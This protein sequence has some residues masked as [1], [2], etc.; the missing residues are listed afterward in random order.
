[1]ISRTSTA[2]TIPLGEILSRIPR[3]SLFAGKEW[4]WAPEPYRLDPK[5]V[6]E[7]ESMGHRLLQFNRACELLYR[8]SVAGKQ[9]AWIASLLDRGKPDGVVSLGRENAFKGLTASV[10]RPDL[11]LTE[12]GFSLCELDQIPGGIGLTAWLNETYSSLGFDV[13]GGANGMLEG[14]AAVLPGGEIVIS[15]EAS[16]YRPE[17]EWIAGRLAELKGERRWHVLNASAK[18]SWSGSVYRFFEMFDLENVPC[19]E[20]LFRDAIGGRVSVT[21]PPKAQLEEKLWM[22]LFWMPPLR[23]FWIRQLG[24]RGVETLRKWIP[25]TWILD[26]S[27]L[28]P[29]AVYPRL[30]IQDWREMAGF[31]QKERDLVIKISGFD[32]RAWGARGVRLGSDLSAKEWT[33]AIDAALSEFPS[34]PHILQVF[35]HSVLTEQSFYGEDGSLRTMKGKAR[36]SPYFFVADHKATLG[37]VLATVCPADKKILHGM[38]VAVMTPVM[39]SR[40]ATFS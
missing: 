10:I 1:V 27:P 33:E 15:E 32:G 17:M 5:L 14:F 12:E 4:R 20:T 3:G 9:P 31:S 35:R 40:E 26:P 24:E 30:E 13:A 2:S 7:L 8:Q 39:A 25:F 18:D 22:A 38:S 29:N 19:A 16:T 6:G 11:I 34:H 23:Q 36:L 28:P 21:P 37:G